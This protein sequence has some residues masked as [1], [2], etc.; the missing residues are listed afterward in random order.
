MIHKLVLKN[1][2]K[3]KEES[4]SFNKFDIIVGANNSGKSTALQALGIW[5]YCVEQ[6]RPIKKSGSRGV[7]VVL[8]NFTALPL[9]EF[10]LLWT[11]KVSQKGNREREQ[12]Y[13]Y[14]EISV[15]WLDHN[16]KEDF[17]T[18]QLRYQSPQAVYAIPAGGWDNFNQKVEQ[19]DFPNIVYVPPFSGL[20]PHESWM[21][22]GNIKQHAGKSQPGSVLRNLLFRVI[23][24]GIP[25][26]DN[27]DWAEITTKI[28]EWFGVDLQ[29]PNYTKGVSTE[30]KVEYKSKGKLFDVISGGSG[31]HQILTLLAFLYGYPEATTILLDEPDAHLHAN[32]QRKIINYFISQN[33]QFFIATHSEEFIKSVDIHSIIS[34]LSDK[35]VRIDSSKKIIKALKD[36]DNNDVLRTQESPFILYIE[37][38][39]DD[40]ILS[41]WAKALGKSDI[42]QKYYP[43]VL[44][45]STKE[46]MKNLSDE[47]YTALK[48]IVPNLQRILILDYDQEGG[49]H[50]EKGNKCLKEWKRK[51]IDNY[52]LV[53]SAWCRAVACSLKEDEDSIFLGPYYNVI[54]DF[55][56][57][58]NLFLPPQSTWRNLSA[59]IF[60]I[61][62]GKKILFED[63]DSLF[64]QIKNVDNKGIAINRQAVAIAMIPDEIHQDVVDFFESM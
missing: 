11:D 64:N 58:Q 31:F 53:P 4:F 42:Y 36:V 10:N 23:D 15:Y 37:G 20:E 51:N 3:M 6:F 48:Q 8:P 19:E 54:N 35:P 55:F 62:D 61:I 25:A 17:L 60:E 45:G 16:G 59:N 9:P 49:Y 57:S 56:A 44:G 5:Q 38:E 2:K 13:I 40:R 29:E 46:I 43:Y 50:P 14:I 21:D 33:K 39:D 7:Q 22:N 27:N 34:I 12:K 26:K 47:H 28:K 41:L 24:R 52:L 63:T 18:V 1:F 32:L 30:I